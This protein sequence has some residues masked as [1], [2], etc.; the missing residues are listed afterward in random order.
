M[1]NDDITGKID[2][3]ERDH[4]Q[5]NS[6]YPTSIHISNRNRESTE[7]TLTEN[8]LD[9]YIMMTYPIDRIIISSPPNGVI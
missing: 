8:I 3:A 4:H 2:I 5:K 6:Y 1:L 9:Y 7:N